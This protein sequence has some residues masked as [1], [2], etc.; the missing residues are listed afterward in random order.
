MQTIPDLVYF[1]DDRPGITRRKRGRGWSYTAPDGTLIADKK[2]RA[3]LDA[4]AVPPAYTDVWMC[5]D[6]LGHLQAT[7]R[8]ARAR[9]QYRYHPDWTAF[10]AR[11]K[12][13]HLRAFGTALPSIR[14]RIQRNL[15]DGEAGD[16][17][18]AIAAILALLDRANLRVGNPDYARQNRTFGATTLRPRHLSLEGGKVH[19]TYRAKGGDLVEKELRDQT[20]NR[21]LDRLDDLGGPT[22]VS[23]E[24]ETGTARAVTSAE[25]NAYLAGQT[26]SDAI[27]AKTFR[28][29]NGTVTAFEV[30]MREE[31]LTI[32]SMTEA[33]AERLHNTPAICRSS[34][35]HPDVIALAETP[36]AERR[37]L[38][39]TAP[40]TRGLRQSEAGLLNLL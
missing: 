9:K 4:M 22:L 40:E 29:W 10:R 28:T 1:P 37:R 26:D 12:F 35:I 13:D 31:S 21:V 5:P 17:S 19:L 6:P 24:D 39:E 30:A 18:F 7:G 15:R 23:W 38:I 20:L 8:D 2:E 32:K 27:T 16:Q 14:R 3:R 33:A 36:L 34:Y 25:V 11:Q